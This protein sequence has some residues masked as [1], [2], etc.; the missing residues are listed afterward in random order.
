MQEERSAAAEGTPGSADSH[1]GR[2]RCF[3]GEITRKIKT[4]LLPKPAGRTRV[5]APTRSEEPPAPSL[6]KRSR[7]I[8]NQPLATVA[9][10]KRAEILLMQKFD[11]VPTREAPSQPAKKMIAEYFEGNLSAKYMDAARELFPSMRR[12]GLSLQDQLAS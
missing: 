11:G 5:A 12:A 3:M 9:S 7:R 8:A 4:P 1:D 2:L 6:P 10:S